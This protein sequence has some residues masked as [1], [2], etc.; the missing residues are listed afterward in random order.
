[1]YKKS[2]IKEQLKKMNAPKD[3]V[4]MVHA[5]LRLVG[6]IEGGGEA[7][8]DALIEYFTEDG[9]LLCVPTHT[10]GNLGTDKITLD[11]TK[12]ES[13]LGAFAVIAAN[14]KRGIRSANPTHS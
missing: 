9:G 3:S 6:E 10:W 4:V 12:G 8:L 1:M 5:S 13:N 11:L 14:D 7:L 2:D